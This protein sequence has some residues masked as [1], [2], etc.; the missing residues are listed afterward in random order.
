MDGLLPIVNPEICFSLQREVFNISDI[1]FIKKQLKL[2]KKK[3][4]VIAL[5]IK[6][7]SKRS[8]DRLFTMMCALMVY[9][10]LEIQ[11]EVDEMNEFM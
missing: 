10:M 8:E 3:N 1:Q 2:L 5:W 6:E 4:P 9:R 7:F 11:F